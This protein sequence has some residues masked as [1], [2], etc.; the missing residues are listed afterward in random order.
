MENQE[1]PK[2]LA[3]KEIKQQKKNLEQKQE[4]QIPKED[5]VVL[6]SNINQKILQKEKNIKY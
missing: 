3:P 2:D 1:G 5:N 6:L 4:G